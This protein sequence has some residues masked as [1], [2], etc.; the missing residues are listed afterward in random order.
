MKIFIFILL[1]L[2]SL[3]YTLKLSEFL[4]FYYID[5]N[6]HYEGNNGIISLTKLDNFR[7][8][9]NGSVL[10]FNIHYKAHT[11]TDQV[12]TGKFEASVYIN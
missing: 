4:H 10:N 9:T 8:S 3:T 11:K 1:A 7:E 12:K 6:L 5:L 2:T